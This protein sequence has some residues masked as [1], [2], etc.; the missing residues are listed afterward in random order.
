[1]GERGRPTSYKKK[2]GEEICLRIAEGESLRTICKDKHIP[3]KST[4]LRWLLDTKSKLYN[5][6]RDQYARAREVQ[7]EGYE[8]ECVDISDDGSNDWMEREVKKGLT[9]T[10]PNYEHIRRSEVRIQTRFKILMQR[11]PKKWGKTAEPGGEKEKLEPLTLTVR[12]E[13]P[14]GKP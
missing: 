8:D 2:L 14:R 6:F 9:V 12:K 11:L 4:I 1:M 5:E 3:D 7:A 13:K 10:V